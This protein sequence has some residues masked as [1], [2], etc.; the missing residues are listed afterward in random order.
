MERSI[1]NE[2][3]VKGS[4]G[5]DPDHPY[6]VLEPIIN[7]FHYFRVLALANDNQLNNES[8][9]V[10]WAT[11]FYLN[12]SNQPNKFFIP[13]MPARYAYGCAKKFLAEQCGKLRDELE[14]DDLASD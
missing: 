7:T 4:L 13:E 6:G 12:D 14:N 1:C 5:V 9:F 11:N 3:P 10:R 2:C 8:E